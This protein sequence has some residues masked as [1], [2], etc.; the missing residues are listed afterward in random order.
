M[1]HHLFIAST[2][3]LI[4]ISCSK[5]DAVESGPSELFY[6]VFVTADETKTINQG[7]KTS[8]AENDRIAVFHAISGTEDYV[9]DKA[10]VVE[11]VST[12]KFSG[13]LQE[14]LD[15]NKEY[16]WYVIYPYDSNGTPSSSNAWSI[17]GATTGQKQNGNN[18]MAHLSGQNYPLVGR[19]KSIPAEEY[20]HVIMKNVSSLVEFTVTNDLGKSITINE[21]SIM[22]EEYIA[23]Y[24]RISYAS[25]QLSF[26]PLGDRYISNTAKLT[27]TN[28][29]A[30]GPGESANYYLGIVPFIA[31]AGTELA[32]NISV[33]DDNSTSDQ[34]LFGTEFEDDV[35]F[36]SGKMTTFEI[37]YNHMF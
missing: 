30:I 31:E 28:G 26:S 33:S 1:K 20:P 3:I 16:D 23:G 34:W 37:H 19:S 21:I 2:I 10:F 18:S 25:D 6:S 29:V 32:V 13:T 7:M 12:G 22:S 14:P 15:E 27:V 17:G 36:E 8:W 11:D 24:F 9:F 5:K 4:A 35:C